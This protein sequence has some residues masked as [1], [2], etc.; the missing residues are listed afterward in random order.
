M[1]AEPKVHCR[2]QQQLDRREQEAE[3]RWGRKRGDGL[4]G[5]VSIQGAPMNMP[6]P[7]SASPQPS[8]PLRGMGLEAC[9]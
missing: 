7:L 2:R 8:L 3:R 4:G 6:G 9:L 1:K 5:L